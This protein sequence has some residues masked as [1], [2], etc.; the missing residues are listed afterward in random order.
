LREREREKKFLCSFVL[1]LLGLP[2]SFLIPI[3]KCFV[4]LSKRHQVCA[5]P[6]G[7]LVTRVIKRRLTRSK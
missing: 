4:K 2:S 3:L 5:G 6:C 1:L 7:V